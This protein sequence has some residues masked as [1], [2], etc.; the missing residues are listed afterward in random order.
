APAA[1]RRAGRNRCSTAASREGRR[2]RRRP[3]TVPRGTAG[4]TAD[5]GRSSYGP[6]L[7][8]EEPP[9]GGDG[10]PSRS[11]RPPPL[12]DHPP[13]PTAV[14]ER[15]SVRAHA[16]GVTHLAILTPTLDGTRRAGG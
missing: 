11:G 5:G 10:T 2:S 6:P 1:A 7:V 12:A 16:A 14:R 4:G 13:R 15:P 8:V 3:P 9:H